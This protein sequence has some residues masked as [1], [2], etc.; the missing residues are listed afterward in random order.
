MHLLSAKVKKG[1][2]FMVSMK[3][4]PLVPFGKFSMSCVDLPNVLSGK[5][6]EADDQRGKK[7]CYTV[8]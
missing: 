1:S 3:I 8:G 7:R 5:D 4:D 6:Q 2:I